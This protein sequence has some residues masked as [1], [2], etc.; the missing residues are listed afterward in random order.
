MTT[1]K[2]FQSV[3]D[4]YAAAIAPVWKRLQA[5]MHEVEQRSHSG[6]TDAAG[7]TADDHLAHLAMWTN[8]LLLM[9]RS[10]RPQWESLGVPRDIFDQALA[11]QDRDELNE[12]IRKQTHG[13]DHERTVSQLTVA[14]EELNTVIM[15]MSDEALQQ[16]MFA[17]AEGGADV[18]LIDMLN[19]LTVR[20]F[21]MHADWIEA[22]LANA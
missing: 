3:K 19:L 18:P 12:L 21:T 17:F 2:Q 16:P 1:D 10:G 6:L 8:S 5:V 14:F 4:V 22:I 11:S 20:H 9:I 7:W 13:W 15:S